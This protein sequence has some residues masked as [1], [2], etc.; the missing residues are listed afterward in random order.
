MKNT[1]YKNHGVVL[2]RSLR[3]P[4]AYTYAVF[5]FDCVVCNGNFFTTG[6]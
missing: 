4:G 2:G 3:L 5:F 6:H 1:L